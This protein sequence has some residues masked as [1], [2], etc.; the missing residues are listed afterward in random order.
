MKLGKRW[1][2]KLRGYLEYWVVSHPQVLDL[3]KVKR[4]QD[5]K[6]LYFLIS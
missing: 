6:Y 5:Q 3:V 1:S 4:V 2:E